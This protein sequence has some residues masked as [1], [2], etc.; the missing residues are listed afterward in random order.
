MRVTVRV[1]ATSANLGPGF[2]CFGLAL[3]LANVFA[4]ETEAEPGISWEGEGASELPI[5]GSDMVSRAMAL[6]A[7]ESG[8]ALPAHRLHA[9][10]AIPLERGLGSSSCAAVAG[11]MLGAHLFDLPER[12]DLSW[13]LRL[14]TRL[15]G[16]PDNAAAAI[17][18]GFTLAP[19]EGDVVRLDPHPS[20]RPVLL[21]PD[22]RLSTAEARKALASLIPRQDA[23]YNVSHA[24][25]MVVALTQRPDLLALAMRDRLHQ[26]AR[27]ALVPAVRDVFEAIASTGVPVAV[28]GAGPT[29]LAFETEAVPVPDPGEG[30]RVLRP[31]VSS[32]GARISEG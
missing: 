17:C 8:R 12:S 32:E 15:E 26:D 30:W 4:L 31:G 24:A 7:H 21:I 3:D 29:L 18:G 28:S 14:A 25:L 22:A 2:D 23:V 13:L 27:L 1:P 6:V 16:H 9:V 10:N 20:L 5:D 11:V 19:Q